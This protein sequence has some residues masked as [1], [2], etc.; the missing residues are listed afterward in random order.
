MLKVFFRNMLCY[1]TLDF[2]YLCF[3][4]CILANFSH[5]KYC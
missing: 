4:Y 2:A 5:G 1:H 3:R